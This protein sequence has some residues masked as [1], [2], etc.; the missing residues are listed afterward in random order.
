[1]CRRNSGRE[2]N[3]QAQGEEKNQQPLELISM[4]GFVNSLIPNSIMLG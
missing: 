2:K 1:V 3:Q 4:I